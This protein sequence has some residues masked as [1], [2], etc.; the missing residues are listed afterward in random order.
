MNKE[1]IGKDVVLYSNQA[2]HLEKH[3]N[4]FI[5]NDSYIQS[6]NNIKDI[7][8]QP[9]FISIDNKNNSLLFIKKMIDNT[10][11]AVRITNKKELK[12]R[13]MYPINESKKLRLKS[14]H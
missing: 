2:S 8:I 6:R 5:N 3:K 10:L 11:V 1:I 4:E 14:I 13:T 9:E 7:L 12:V